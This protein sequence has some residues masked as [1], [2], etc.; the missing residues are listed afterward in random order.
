MS[1]FPPPPA[2]PA[3]T[4]LEEESRG[5]PWSIGQALCVVGVFSGV[6]P[7][8]S[9]LVASLS[10]ATSE[11]QRLALT[12]PAVLGV[13]H[14]LGWLGAFGLVRGVHGQAFFASMRLRAFDLRAGQVLGWLGL[15]MGMQVLARVWVILAPPPLTLDFPLVHYLELGPGAVAF[16]LV[17]VVLMA[18]VLEE[19]LFRG[20]LFPALRRRMSFWPAALLVTVLFTALHSV[21]FLAYLPALAGIAALGLLLAWQ[22]ERTGS[23]W[24]SILLHTGFNLL[25]ILPLLLLL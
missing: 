19:V 17:M 15:G 23:L 20:L 11:S 2:S 12:V 8:L 6:Q 13:S 25:G 24:P 3:S 1:E 7:T 10:G 9:L 21:Q 5:V 18:P 14:L 22:R 4:A 16:L